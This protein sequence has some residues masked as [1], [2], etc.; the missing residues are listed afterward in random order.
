MSHKID[1]I[2]Y[3][4]SKAGGMLRDARTLLE[5][6]S[7]SSAVNR[8]YYALFYEV[9]AL[10]MTKDMSSSKHSGVRSLF[11]EHF[12]KTGLVDTDYGKF[13]SVMY[14]FRQKGDY[15]DFAVFEKERVFDWLSKSEAF[16]SELE[17]LIDKL[18]EPSSTNTPNPKT[19]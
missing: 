16:L 11:N 5:T 15:E 8:I 13:L 1:L 10:L 12:V 9:T 6:G 7:L 2:N 14:D 18:I 3:R 4:R 17:R 19:D